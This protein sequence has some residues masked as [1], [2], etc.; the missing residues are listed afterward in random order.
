MKKVL[1]FL[2]CL[3]M[4]CTAMMAS[5]SVS[6]GSIAIDAYRFLQ[7]RDDDDMVY[8][9][10]YFDTPVRTYEFASWVT[11][12]HLLDNIADYT[13]E[14]GQEL[15]AQYLD[16]VAQKRVELY[17]A[18]VAFFEENFQ[19]EADRLIDASDFKAYIMVYTSKGRLIAAAE[20]TSAGISC[21]ATKE[22]SAQWFFDNNNLR[23]YRYPEKPFTA[24]YEL[25]YALYN[26]GDKVRYLENYV[27]GYKGYMY[28]HEYDCYAEGDSAQ[29]GATP[30][31]VLIFAGSNVCNPAG[32]ADKFGDK[33]FVISHNI[34]Y[35]YAIAYHVITTN[36][37]KVYTLQEAWQAQVPNIDYVFENVIETAIKRG[38]ANA[39][40]DV[41]I[42]DVTFIQKCIAK[43]QSPSEYECISYMDSTFN[44]NDYVSDFNVDGEVNIK[45]ATAIQKMLA[46][47]EYK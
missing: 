37:M 36:D 25:V 46:G 27:D 47:L 12:N 6:A 1:A 22:E 7:A 10:V 28:Y 15:E 20:N 44:G 39:D 33:Y 11:A 32:T 3:C 31:Y 14:Y 35:P 13:V 34:Y 5:L 16:Y 30:D 17:D 19:G 18:N 4:L 8:A 29:T 9:C 2:L 40:G 24:P 26:Q 43:L 21:A 45:D 23:N 41:N 42:Q 38:D